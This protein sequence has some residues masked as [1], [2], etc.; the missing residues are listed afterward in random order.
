[1]AAKA[2]TAFLENG[3]HVFCEKPPAR[4]LSELL[5]V[6]ATEKKA[7]GVKLKYGFNI[8]IQKFSEFMRKIT[9]GMKK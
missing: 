5:P 3:I 8:T 6:L 9:R 2:T 7:K 4:N 1:M